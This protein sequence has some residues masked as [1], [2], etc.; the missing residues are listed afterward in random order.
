MFNILDFLNDYNIPI[1]EGKNSSVGRINIQCPFPFCDDTSDHLG[2]NKEKEYFN[3]WKCGYHSLYDTIKELVPN[4]NP[5]NII[6]K[7]NT[8][9][10]VEEKI[11]KKINNTNIKLP[12]SKLEYCHK[13]Y[14]RSR[15]LDPDFIENKYK[16]KGTLYSSEYPYRIIIPVYYN[17]RL[18]TYQTRGIKE[19]T[20]YINCNPELEIIPIK[21]CLYNLD[22][23]KSNYVVVTEGCFKVFKLGDNSCGTFGKN[24]TNKQI[25]LL[26]KYKKIFIY[27][28]NDEAGKIGADKLSNILDSLEKKVYVINNKINPDDLTLNQVSLFW[29]KLF[30][31]F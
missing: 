8:L 4:E 30:N 17:N 29:D 2:Y 21:D 20:R 23:C 6:K 10:Q 13:K 22:N 5:Y 27:F 15:G 7:Y 24:I 19:N 3:C 1:P 16:L 28:D 31:S 9:Y 12:G 26:L 25:Q 11:K 18:V 14:L